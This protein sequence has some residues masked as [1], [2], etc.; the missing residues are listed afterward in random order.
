MSTG[1]RVDGRAA[2]RARNVD[3]VLDALHD[4][5]V[6]TGAVPGVEEVAE[7]SGVSL[8]SIY[9]YFPDQRDMLLAALARQLARNEPLYLLE[10]VGEGSLEERVAALV[11]QRL[12]IYEQA[13]PTIR[14]A[15]TVTGRLPA[16]ADAVA[17]RRRVLGEQVRLHF[18]PELAS[19]PEAEADAALACVRMLTEF[20][21]LDGERVGQGRS[22]EEVRRTLVHGITALLRPP[23][24][25]GIGTEGHPD[26]A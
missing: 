10:G 9:R 25:A 23:G 19:L 24:G 2:R 3:A 22:P 5:F 11:D 6:E 4:V 20:S 26:R 16:V 17:G 1:E 15:L 12:A 18:A 14:A 21:A 13:A 8:R 7:R